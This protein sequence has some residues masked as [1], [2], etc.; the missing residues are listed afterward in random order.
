MGKGTS[1][2]RELHRQR[3][4]G[5]GKMEHC[6]QV[7]LGGKRKAKLGPGVT[8][9]TEGCLLQTPSSWVLL[10]TAALLLYPK[11]QNIFHWPLAPSHCSHQASL[12]TWPRAPQV[13]G[14][15]PWASHP[16][17]CHL[18]W[19]GPACCLLS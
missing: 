18:R 8:V 12:L 1:R 19:S 13:S 17:R 5:P 9:T 3:P 16:C 6:G 11:P 2:Q 10:E 14:W 4:G 15:R 7:S